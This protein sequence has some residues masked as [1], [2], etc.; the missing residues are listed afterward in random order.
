MTDFFVDFHAVSIGFLYLR[1]LYDSDG[2]TR[3]MKKIPQNITMSYIMNTESSYVSFL[4]CKTEKNLGEKT[5]KFVTTYSTYTTWKTPQWVLTF[6]KQGMFCLSFYTV[7][8]RRTNLWHSY[9]SRRTTI[10]AHVLTISLQLS[11]CKF[12]FLYRNNHFS[13]LE[14]VFEYG[15]LASQDHF[16]NIIILMIPQ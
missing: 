4:D 11:E 9:A 7:E 6:D 14:T 8:G 13:S 5:A 12:F 16:M 3:K 10:F 1:V 2:N 15:N